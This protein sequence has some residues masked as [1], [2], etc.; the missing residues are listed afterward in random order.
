MNACTIHIG[1]KEEDHVE[2]AN[3]ESTPVWRRTVRTTE[4]NLKDCNYTSHHILVSN[5]GKAGMSTTA[6]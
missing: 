3:K 1:L 6:E 4:S 5:V 2:S